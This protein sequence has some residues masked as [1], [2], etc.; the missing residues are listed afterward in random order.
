MDRF[1][2]IHLVEFHF[3]TGLAGKFERVLQALI[4]GPPSQ[5]T[6]NQASIRGVT[7]PC[8]GERSMQ[9]YV[10]MKRIG[11]QKMPRRQSHSHRSSG[12]GA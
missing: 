2:E 7:M 3:E 12:V 6:G 5:K 8:S 11:P 4:I 10:C 1:A 9:A